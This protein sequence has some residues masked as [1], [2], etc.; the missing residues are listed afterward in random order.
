VSPRPVRPGGPELWIGGLTPPGVER[1]ARLGRGFV[2]VLPDQIGAYVEARRRLGLDD[3]RVA[4]GN[5]WIVAEDPERTLAAIGD[6]VL[7]QVNAYIEFG[8]F[9]PPDQVPRLTDPQQLV[10]M[11]HYRLLDANGA[12]AELGRQ[13]AAGPVVDCFSWTLFPG[14][15]VDSAAERLQYAADHLIPAVRKGMEVSRG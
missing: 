3:G 15:P 1:A 8:A 7:Y 10:D 9:G 11:G 12:A 4:V 2:C 5:Q 13:L 6:H 14:E